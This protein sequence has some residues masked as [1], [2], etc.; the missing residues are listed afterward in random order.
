MVQAWVMA[1]PFL[2]ST[3]FPSMSP[4]IAADLASRSPATLKLAGNEVVLTSRDV[5]WIGY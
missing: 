1:T 3:H 5:P 4:V 2:G